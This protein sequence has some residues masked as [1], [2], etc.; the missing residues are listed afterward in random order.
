MPNR[1]VKLLASQS[2]QFGGHCNLEAWT[3]SIGMMQTHIQA[4]LITL[5]D[6][7]QNSKMFMPDFI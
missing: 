4:E 5:W 3:A 7:L 1:V 6:A 2:S